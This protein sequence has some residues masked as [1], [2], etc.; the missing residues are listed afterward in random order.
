MIR[1]LEEI[2]TAL[3]HKLFQSALALALTIPDI[4]GQI[5]YPE[6]VNSKTGKRKI[7]Q[8]YIRWFDNYVAHYYADDTGWTDDYKYAKNS[9]FTGQMCY[10]LRC[11]F[12]HSGNDDIVH[13]NDLKDNKSN[14]NFKF[15]LSVNGSDSV[16]RI[17]IHNSNDIDNP[18]AQ[19]NVTLDI[20]NLCKFLRIAGEKYYHDKGSHN[21]KDNNLII[22]DVD[23]ELRNM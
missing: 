14:Y 17:F 23:H 22:L 11:S 7:G 4:C 12:L 13:F 3:N 9:F 18:I 5:E 6:L 21:F 1:K 20:V 16:Q 19:F 8:Q 15:T 10:E 2:S